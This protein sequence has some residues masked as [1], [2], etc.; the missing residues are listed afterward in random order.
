MNKDGEQKKFLLCAYPSLKKK[1]KEKNI[2][3]N[4][5]KGNEKEK[6]KK[7]EKEKKQKGERKH[8]GLNIAKIKESNTMRS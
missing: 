5:E 8:D 6:T 1:R 3:I 2:Q 4:H 7:K